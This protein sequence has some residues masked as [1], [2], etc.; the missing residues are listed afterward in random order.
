MSFF[1][2][3]TGKEPQPRFLFTNAPASWPAIPLT[4]RREVDAR[5]AGALLGLEIA[6][7]LK[8][9]G[10]PVAR[11]LKHYLFPEGILEVALEPGNEEKHHILVYPRPHPGIAGDFQLSRKLLA[12]SRRTAIYYSVCPVDSDAPASGKLAGWSPDLFEQ[13]EEKL[14][15]GHYSMWWPSDQERCFTGSR[16]AGYIQSAYLNLRGYEWA[17]LTTL[18][19]HLE[20]IEDRPGHFVKLPEELLQLS[21]QGP[22]DV[23]FLLSAS[24]EKGVRFH[25]HESTP[26]DYRNYFWKLYSEFC[27]EVRAQAGDH[28]PPAAFRQESDPLQWLTTLTDMLASQEGKTIVPASVGTIVRK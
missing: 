12:R 16:I 4:V 2:K 14:P 24:Q 26:V 21:L 23:I 3:I 15:A 20:L 8:Q 11:L 22:D 10:L 17:L 18:A 9:H 27:A 7:R 19:K 25:F 6:T 13:V 1:R 5:Q 28:R